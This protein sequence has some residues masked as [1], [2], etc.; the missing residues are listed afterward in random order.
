MVYRKIIKQI[1]L[2]SAVLIVSLCAKDVGSKP[3]QFEITQSSKKQFFDY[4]ST[5]SYEV[6]ITNIGEGNC[7]NMVTS[8][9]LL[10]NMSII[11][12]SVPDEWSCWKDHQ[13][14]QTVGCSYNDTLLAS[15]MHMVPLTFN[16][17]VAK[18][19]DIQDASWIGKPSIHSCTI[20]SGI[21]SIFKESVVS[22]STSCLNLSLIQPFDVNAGKDI[23]MTVGDTVLI[24]GNSSN[25]NEYT[26]QYIWTDENNVT[27]AT[28]ASFN[29]TAMKIG[30]YVLTITAISDADTT[31]LDTM[32]LTVSP[33]PNNPPVV[34]VGNDKT[35]TVSKKPIQ[36]TCTANDSDGNITDYRWYEDNITLASTAIL[37]YNISK[38]GTHTLGC[39][40]TD[41]DNATASDTMVLTVTSLPVPNRPPIVDAG[42]DKTVTVSKKP[43]QITC[44][45]NDSDGNITGYR[46]YEDNI[47]LAST[48][49]LGYNISK[50]GTHTLGC[51]ATDDD[52]ATASDTMVLTI[53]K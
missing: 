11:L 53:T 33:N 43:I 3:C 37:D 23:N 44:T 46:W 8:S 15:G 1:L 29:Y 32:V 39:E 6:N 49:I 35:V 21:N 48:A 41:D 30:I 22:T 13:N 40:A 47:T 27:L 19:K 51:E 28:T 50:I 36:I 18:K 10:E 26:L 14:P 31:A 7:Y 16:V 2:L 38:I 52:N 42:N 9:S 24:T 17:K 20:V 5:L 25:S 4:N 34:V 45:A 12:D